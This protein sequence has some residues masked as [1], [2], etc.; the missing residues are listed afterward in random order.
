MIKGV[1]GCHA[2]LPP[3]AML[4]VPLLRVFPRKLRLRVGRFIIV[5]LCENPRVRP[6]GLVALR[7]LA[8]IPVV[9]VENDASFFH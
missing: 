3:T 4:G 7:L 5:S 2:N 9:I 8:A 6:V 1:V